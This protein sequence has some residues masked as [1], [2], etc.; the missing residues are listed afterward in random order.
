MYILALPTGSL[1]HARRYHPGRTLTFWWHEKN[2]MDW[3]RNFSG[4]SLEN[5]YV[6]EKGMS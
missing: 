5:A 1:H 2:A 6:V 3:R 4:E